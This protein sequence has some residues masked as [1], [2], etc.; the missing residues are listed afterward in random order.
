MNQVQK[1]KFVKFK[2]GPN[3]ATKQVGIKSIK[4]QV[5][6]ILSTIKQAISS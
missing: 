6:K 5:W 1:Y 3:K 2:P 4:K